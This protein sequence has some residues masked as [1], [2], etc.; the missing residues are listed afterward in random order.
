M[1]WTPLSPLLNP[2][3]SVA[4]SFAQMQPDSNLLLL[5]HVSFLIS[6]WASKG[7]PWTSEG[8]RLINKCFL[9]PVD[10]SKA[11]YIA[12]PKDPVA[13]SSGCP[14][15][16]V[17]EHTL[18]LGVHLT[19]IFLCCFLGSLPKINYLHINFASDSTLWREFKGSDKRNEGTNDNGRK[20][21]GKTILI[22]NRDT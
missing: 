19:L 13:L 17:G 12:C 14:Q 5:H 15:R 20:L 22:S 21:Y 8:W 3:I 16:A 1:H 6:P 4:A 9:S 18:R 11:N 7:Q 2:A 10:N